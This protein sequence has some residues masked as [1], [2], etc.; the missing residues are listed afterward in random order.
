MTPALDKQI[1]LTNV[2]YWAPEEA[3]WLSTRHYLQFIQPQTHSSSSDFFQSLLVRHCRECSRPCSP[4]LFFSLTTAFPFQTNWTHLTSPYKGPVWKLFW[5]TGP[6]VCVCVRQVPGA[7]REAIT[8][9]KLKHLWTLEKHFM[10]VFAAT[11]IGPLRLWADLFDRVWG[12]VLVLI[13][14][15]VSDQ[16]MMCTVHV[17][18]W[19]LNP[20]LMLD[21]APWF[22]FVPHYQSQ[23]AGGTRL[24]IV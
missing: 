9:E 23:L 22:G 4:S 6:G 24:C 15:C 8:M 19:S 10:C 18:L 20:V 17:S 16:P 11:V 2:I 12:W 21:M 1:Y 14:L 7:W 5:H 3:E 13:T